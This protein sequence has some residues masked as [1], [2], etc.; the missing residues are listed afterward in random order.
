MDVLATGVTGS[1]GPSFELVHLPSYVASQRA[2]HV[3]TDALDRAL[4]SD[5]ANFVHV[6]E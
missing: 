3:G 4:T 6:D 1:I 5:V 2:Y